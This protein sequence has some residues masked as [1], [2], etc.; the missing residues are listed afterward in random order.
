MNILENCNIL[1]DHIFLIKGIHKAIVLF[2][3]RMFN[4]VF[5]YAK[6][7]GMERANVHVIDIG[8]YPVFFK[9]VCDAGDKLFSRLLRERGYQDILRLYVALLDEVNCPLYKGVGLSR[10]GACDYKNGAI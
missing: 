1:I 9:F 7:D 10:S 4:M 3:P 6:A 8:G 5:Q 2:E